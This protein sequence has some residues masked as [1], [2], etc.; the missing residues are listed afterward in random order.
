LCDLVLTK[1]KKA[2]ARIF[3]ADDLKPEAKTALTK[4]KA[5]GL[6]LVMLS[7]DS[8]VK[9]QNTAAELEIESVFSRHSP[10]QK[11]AKLAELEAKTP[12]GYVGDGINDAPA[13]SQARV[14][15][16]LSNASQI[17]IQS[18]QV[19][20]HRGSLSAL[21]EAVHISRLTL[22]TIKQ[23]LFWAFFY[24]VLAIPLAAAGYLSPIIAALAM[25]LSD[26]FVIG[27]SLRLRLR[28]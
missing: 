22:K 6:K 4:L 11:L 21:V 13:L 16:S 17:A 19:I 8:A 23:N 27:N 24:N 7:G 10:A 25:A 12:T 26:V 15:I 20:L 1:N 14:G 2:V 28:S 18:A 9:C 3:L 5:M